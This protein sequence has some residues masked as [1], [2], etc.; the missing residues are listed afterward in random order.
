MSSI[1]F[2]K[3]REV[4]TGLYKIP[5]FE[6]LRLQTGVFE[7]EATVASGQS[8]FVTRHDATPSLYDFSFTK[9]I[10]KVQNLK[11]CLYNVS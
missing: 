10:E 4:E 7:T 2:L 3:F 6:M 5:R 1:Q 9:F 11:F 8:W